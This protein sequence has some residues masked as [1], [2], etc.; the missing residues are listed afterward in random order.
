MCTVL[1]PFLNIIGHYSDSALHYCSLYSYV[2]IIKQEV[3]YCVAVQWKINQFVKVNYKVINI[4]R[5][6]N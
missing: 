5:L 6:K 2:V 1:Q 4:Y 3:E